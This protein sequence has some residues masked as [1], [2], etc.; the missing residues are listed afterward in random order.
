MLKKKYGHTRITF[1]SAEYSSGLRKSIGIALTRD[2]RMKVT[3]ILLMLS[4]CLPR[5][6]LNQQHVKQNIRNNQHELVLLVSYH[7][8]KM[9]IQ[10][11]I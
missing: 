10:N 5:E 1:S 11:V 2:F 7:I 3:D 9:K 6:R 8:K 4:I